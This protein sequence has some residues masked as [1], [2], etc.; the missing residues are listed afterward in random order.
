MEFV[1]RHW[2]ALSV[3]LVLCLVLVAR[4]V[5]LQHDVAH[6]PVQ[7][8]TVAGN[9]APR[10]ELPPRTVGESAPDTQPQP[11]DGTRTLAVLS[12]R[13][14]DAVSR[15]PVHEFTLELN[16]D[17]MGRSIDE[18]PQRRAFSADD[19]RFEWQ[20][21]LP[22]DWTVVV[23]AGGYQQ[24]VLRSSQVSGAAT[25]AM[26]LPLRR[27]YRLKGRLY[28][29]A[30]GLGVDAARI[31][32]REASLHRFDISLLPGVFV[33]SKKNGSFVLEGVPPGRVTIEV[34]SRRYARR[35]IDVLVDDTTAPLE[36]GLSAGGLI[37]GRL[38]AADG[39]TPVT[40]TAGIFY[41]DEGHG[42]SNYTGP[43]GEFS[44][45]HL[46]A[47]RFHITGEAGGLA[48]AKDITLAEGERVEAMVLALPG[49]RS[50]RGRVTGVAPETLRKVR[51]TVNRA[52]AGA[53]G[54]DGAR[55]DDGGAYVVQGVPPGSAGLVAEVGTTRR[56]AKTIEMPA[57]SDLT[58]NFDFPPAARLSGR[59]TRAG[60]PLSGVS[61]QSMPIDQPGASTRA[62]SATEKGEYVFEDMDPGE[63]Y[64]MVDRYRSR[65]VRVS[66]DTVF[67][68]DVP[69]AQLSGRVLEVAG[70]VPIVGAHVSLWSA[71]ADETPIEQYSPSDHAGHFELAGLEPED[72]ILTVYKP[73]YEMFRQRISYT[74][75]VS[76]MTIP[77]RKG[78]GVE[79]RLRGANDGVP[80]RHAFVLERFGKRDG[81]RLAPQIDENG[82][83]Y[84]PE[85]L[86][87]S[88]L[89]FFFAGY[90]EIVVRDWD[91]QEI[92]LQL[93]PEKK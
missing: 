42:L 64:V 37:G 11:D 90:T 58:I 7:V 88:T 27:G 4:W 73:G 10:E 75:P 83:G 34:D 46:P 68:V 93:V 45:E 62:V 72:F 71:Q 80:V 84:I 36:I 33:N 76:G 55:T 87:G 6:A 22:K 8:E 35:E 69:L 26:V 48:V 47:G 31:G 19:G 17:R 53:F 60:K 77:L 92:D 1:T 63:Y 56:L 85:A 79:F 24:F 3:A 74:A 65:A 52:D 20:G 29:Q 86:V 15:E 51:I 44:F 13:V 49:G 57:D 39:V 41:A 78:N 32:F 2:L 14:I 43:A 54:S 40:G 21:A 25:T 23:K 50:I 5:V 38:T 18:P 9:H 67:D 59:V 89:S 91:G 16:D 82:V 81:V 30:S 12:G 28:D 70:E 66:G 61:L